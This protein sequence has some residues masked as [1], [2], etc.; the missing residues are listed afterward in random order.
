MV[1]FS[2]NIDDRGRIYVELP[3]E[4]EYLV[5][6][7][8]RFEERE[9]HVITGVLDVNSGFGSIVYTSAFG[10]PSDGG[11]KYPVKLERQ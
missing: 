3:R 7:R 5:N 8:S 6:G 4:S 2:S 10:T 9:Y 11:C 1:S